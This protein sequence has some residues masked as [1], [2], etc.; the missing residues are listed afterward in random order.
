MITRYSFE[1]AI[2]TGDKLWVP[3]FGADRGEPLL[4][5]GALYDLGF[6]TSSVDDHGLPMFALVMTLAAFLALFL[7]AATALTG[8]AERG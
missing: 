8:R 3:K 7:S 6:R 5:S 2:Q 4:V 1:A